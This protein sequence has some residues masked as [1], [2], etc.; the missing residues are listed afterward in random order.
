MSESPPERSRGRAIVTGASSFVGAHLAVAFAKN[1]YDVAAL[2]TKPLGDYDNLRRARL[3]HAGGAARLIRRDI[4]NRDA[5]LALLAEEKPAL[6]VHHVGDTTNYTRPDYDWIGALEITARPLGFLYPAFRANGTAVIV[7]G[8]DQEYGASDHLNREDDVCRPSTPYGLSKLAE[9]M[10]ARQ[11]ALLHEVPTRIARVYIPF[12]RFDNPAK[13]LP[14][15]VEAL[16][17]GRAMDLSAG[18]QRR[19][20]MGIADI[21]RAYVALAGDMNRTMVDVFNVSSGEPTQL[22]TLLETLCD[23]IGA[24]RALLN[25]GALPM[26]PGEPPLSCGDASKA[27]E[28]LGWQ[29][30]PLARAVAEDLLDR[31]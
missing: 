11:L 27:R 16:R 13:L 12:G 28:I 3:D 7:T 23:E 24:D 4:R 5:T 29:A 14:Q 9:S 1:G 19:D 8:T 2:H 6:W 22:R 20:F 17:E 21:C 18:E 26:R 25:F 30:R 31:S 10:A 15:V